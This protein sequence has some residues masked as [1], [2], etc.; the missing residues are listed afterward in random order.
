MCVGI[1]CCCAWAS[2]AVGLAQAAA[3][4][5]P[6]TAD[7]YVWRNTLDFKPLE[8]YGG[9]SYYDVLIS[10]VADAISAFQANNSGIKAYLTLQGETG[11]R[12]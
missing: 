11:G 5:V 9:Y 4:A 7:G 6:V 8:Q 10:P 12:C 1:T 3:G 2:L